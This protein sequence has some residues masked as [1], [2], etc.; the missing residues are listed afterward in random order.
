MSKQF[1]KRHFYSLSE[2]V[3]KMIDP[4]LRKRTG[5]N[6]ALLEH[7]PQIAGRDIG[8]HTVPLKIIWKCRV[9]QDRIFQP[10]TLVVACER[11]AALKLLHETDELLHRI[12]GFFGYVVL[13]RIKIEQRCVSVLNDH[14]QTKLALSEKD[15]KCVE[16]MLEGVE[17]ESLRQ[18]LYELGCCIFAEKKSK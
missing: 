1:Q 17:N 14:L 2:T 11:F 4:V 5:L 7:W 10:A 12:N 9:D 13:D 16:K 8:E 15:K 18:S 3:S 6:V